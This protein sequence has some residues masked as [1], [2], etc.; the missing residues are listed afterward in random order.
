ML[1][2]LVSFVRDYY[3]C[4]CVCAQSCLILCNP[5]NSSPSGSSVYGIFQ[6]RILEWVPF[7]TTGDLS[8]PGIES[9]SLVSPALA[10][11]FFTTCKA[12]RLLQAISSFHYYFFVC[13]WN[14]LL[15]IDNK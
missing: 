4:V 13:N 1:H 15:F 14:V 8:V 10:G 6:V 7:P 5:M 12:P 11:G 9:T 2:N 3:V